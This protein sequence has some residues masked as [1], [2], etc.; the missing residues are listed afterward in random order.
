MLGNLQNPPEPFG[1]IIRTHFRLKAN[2]IRGQLDHWLAQDDGRA[3]LGDGA[4]YSTPQ[5]SEGT[6]G[7]GLKKDIDEL[8]RILKDLESGKA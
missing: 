4:G 8:K 3:T 6:S 2:S 5:K 7:N 1:D